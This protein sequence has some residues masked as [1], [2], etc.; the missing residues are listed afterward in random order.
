MH[1]IQIN[2]PRFNLISATRNVETIVRSKLKKSN[3]A[4]GIQTNNIVF[5]YTPH[6]LT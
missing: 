6:N 3:N 5:N 4:Y 2:N 1:D